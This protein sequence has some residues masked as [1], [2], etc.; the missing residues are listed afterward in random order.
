MEDPMHEFEAYLAEVDK[1]KRHQSLSKKLAG[2]PEQG[3][4]NLNEDAHMR[5]LISSHYP[6]M[7]EPKPDP[8][9]IHP[10]NSDR[11]KRAE[12][13]LMYYAFKEGIEPHLA[14]GVSVPAHGLLDDLMHL[15]HQRGF[16]VQ[17]FF[18]TVRMDKF[19][20]EL[21]HPDYEEILGESDDDES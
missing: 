5:A 11:A 13:I 18:E 14:A 8:E 19:E 16:G 6:E 2:V 7:G 15:C 9:D 20:K 10:N 1:E 4:A 3:A 17:S 12:D 21:R